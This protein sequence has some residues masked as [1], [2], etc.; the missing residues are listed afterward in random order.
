MQKILIVEDEVKVANAIRKGLEENGFEVDV[1][2]DG[3]VGK[4]LATGN[5]Y[6]M[7]ILDLN[8]PHN[9]GYEVCEAVR[10]SNNRVPII[11]LTALGGMEDKMQAFGLGA[12]D[13]LVKPFDFRELLAR[14]RVFLKRAGA[15]TP[16]NT[17]YK[18]AVSDLEIDREKKEV[19]RAGKKIALTAKEYQLLEFLALHKGRVISKLTI[20]EKV[21]DIDFD[22]GTNVIEVYINFLR[23]KIDKDFEQKLLHT[24]TGMG[25]Y[26]SE[27]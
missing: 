2:Y 9:N 21:W 20:A 19:T 22:T 6:D 5:I 25:Y 10:R 16:L 3:R 13:Y 23:K 11:M 14:I 4:S 27:E 17:Q 7:L 8:L 1:A 26:L 18:I 15:D 12:D 24:K